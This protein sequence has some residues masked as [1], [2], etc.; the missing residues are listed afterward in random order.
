MNAACAPTR[1]SAS[2]SATSTISNH[3]MI[4]LAP[5][6][7]A[8]LKAGLATLSESLFRVKTASPTTAA[9]GIVAI[10][11]GTDANGAFSVAESACGNRVPIHELP[12]ESE[13]TGGFPVAGVTSQRPSANSAPQQLLALRRRQP[14]RTLLRA[15]R[16]AFRQNSDCTGLLT[17]L[18]APS[19]L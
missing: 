2:S 10:L 9:R 5:G 17:P 12:R 15:G 11:P 3:S 14:L 6:D 13:S 7:D 19:A 4:Y 1:R 18:L 8:C 16:T